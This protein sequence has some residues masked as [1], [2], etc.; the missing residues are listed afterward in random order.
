MI[1]YIAIRYTSRGYV[2][3]TEGGQRLSGN[4]GTYA[5]ARKYLV[6]LEKH[7]AKEVPSRDKQ[8]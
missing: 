6:A 7:R 3:M 8:N 1:D 4:Y 5:E 2:V